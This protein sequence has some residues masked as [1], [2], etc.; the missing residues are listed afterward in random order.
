[1]SVN[2]RNQ[3]LDVLRCIAILLVLG[4]HYEY[5]GLWF[6]VG[7]SG[8]DLFF[9]LSGFLISGLLFGEYQSRGS[10]DL[11]RFWIRR[12]FKIYPAFYAFLL[13]IIIAFA[14]TGQLT[15]NIYSDLFF[16][17]DYIRP[18][19]EH[20][21]SLGVEE[22]F[23]FALPVLLIVIMRFAKSRPDPFRYVPHIF[24]GLFVACLALRVDAV[25]HFASWY[26]VIFPAHL[27][28]DSLF[29][30][31]A[32]GYYR[33]FH[34]EQFRRAGRLPLWI[35][36]LLLLIP[37][38]IW[39]LRTPQITTLGL[40][41][42]AIGYG[43]IVLWA[44]NRDFGGSLVVRGLA[45]IGRFSYSIYLWHRVA[46]AYLGYRQAGKHLFTL[47]LYIVAG[48]GLG[49]LAAYLIETPFLELR[50]RLYPSQ[51]AEAAS[52]KSRGSD[53]GV[54]GDFVS[55]KHIAELS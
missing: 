40:S 36:G 29:A 5:P 14:A 13:F 20:G 28:C 1:L 50:D 15:R 26:P 43:L 54:I 7:W 25:M 2:S 3:S 10:I 32:L 31:V 45:W 8:V 42:N 16:L 21:W 23:Y 53:V 30:G 34:S 12:A 17:Q 46:T 24:V 48:I 11:K 51:K 47:P 39:D 18:I 37:M 22:K 6:K 55:S 35:P 44:A 33:S 19:V 38:T 41:M 9:V 4:H 49:W 27:R 52:L